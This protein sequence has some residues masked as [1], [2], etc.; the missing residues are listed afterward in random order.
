MGQNTM[1]YEGTATLEV[2]SD[3]D[4]QDTIVA[5]TGAMKDEQKRAFYSSSWMPP[6]STSRLFSNAVREVGGAIEAERQPTP[7]TIRVIG[8]ELFLT[9]GV[10][11]R[12]LVSLRRDAQDDWLPPTE[13]AYGNAIDLLPRAC[14][15]IRAQHPGCGPLPA[16]LLSTDSQ[17]GIRIAWHSGR[18]QV[19]ANF[20]ASTTSRSYIYFESAPE[21]GVEELQVATLAERLYWLIEE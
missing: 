4:V 15:Q 1:N 20:G 9:I 21:H 17:G 5:T 16:P 14:F 12:E 7:T 11:V 2:E 10:M 8:R 18:K 3:L 6:Y 19:R 13:Q